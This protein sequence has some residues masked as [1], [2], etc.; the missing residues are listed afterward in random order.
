MLH[1][2]PED[3]VPS[4]KQSLRTR[5]IFA[6]CARALSGLRRGSLELSLPSG[7]RRV[8]RGRS[9]GVHASIQLNNFGV[10]WKSLRRGT[11]GFAD[12]YIDGDFETSNLADLFRFFLDNKPDLEDAGRGW[13]KVRRH[14]R[15]FHR[16][17]RN[18]VRGAK[19]NITDHYDLGNE[20]YAQWLDETMTYSSAYYTA[21]EQPLAE[22]QRAKYN[23]VLAALGKSA[24]G[25]LLEI[26]C[27][28]GGF[29]E[30]A[31]QRGAQVDGITISQSQLDYARARMDAA[32]LSNI[33]R[34]EERDYRYT[35]GQY[36]GVVSIEMIEAVGEE[37]WPRYFQVIY[38]RLRRGGHA[39]LQCITISE[40]FFET[41]RRQ[42]DFIQR[43]I[44]PGGMLP[45]GSIIGREARRA[46][47][48]LD[49]VETFG[50]SYART[51][52][53]WRDNFH[54]RWP[55]IRELGFDERF[56]R[57]WDYYLTYCAV[58]FE[59]G[60]IDVGLYKLTKRA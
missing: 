46:G 39:V 16:R 31:G 30:A 41:Y 32:G 13:F 6:G 47:L 53:T 18:S 27:G 37:H 9:E 35:S 57:L 20:F 59:R 2:R 58:G 49:G 10:F 25:R 22:A 14:D 17:R 5:L 56:R 45:C 21:P 55:S 29:A 43:Y 60:T 1:K 3:A 42:V 44:F 50:P 15:K 19:R 51:L 23:K 4:D 8:F 28:W 48:E 33:C 12:S 26:G 11:V 24:D 36:D 52:W 34:I 7:G 54:A 40:D 38:D